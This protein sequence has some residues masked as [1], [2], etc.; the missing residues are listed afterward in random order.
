MKSKDVKKTK[1]YRVREILICHKLNHV[2]FEFQVVDLGIDIII[3]IIIGNGI[4]D[5]GISIGTA[6]I[7]LC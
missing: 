2:L 4:V 7:G 5:L 1:Q 3:G 6:G